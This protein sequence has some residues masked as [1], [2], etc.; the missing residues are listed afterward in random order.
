MLIRPQPASPRQG[1]ALEKRPRLGPVMKDG[2]PEGEDFY[3][4]PGD[5]SPPR[6]GS[7]QSCRRRRKERGDQ[8][9]AEDAEEKGGPDDRDAAGHV[10]PE[11]SGD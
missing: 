7:Q 2:L 10:E 1:H 4:E 5:D 3:L 9:E 11:E 6:D 8:A